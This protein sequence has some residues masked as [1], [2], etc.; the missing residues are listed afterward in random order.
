MEITPQFAPHGE[1]VCFQS[2]G[3][4]PGSWTPQICRL[5]YTWPWDQTLLS[6][7]WGHY[8]VITWSLTL[9]IAHNHLLLSHYRPLSFPSTTKVR[10]LHQSV[11]QSSLHVKCFRNKLKLHPKLWII[12][13]FIFLVTSI[14]FHTQ[15][16]STSQIR[17]ELLSWLPAKCT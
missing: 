13:G 12:T 4:H 9:Q 16:Y 8:E 14:K 15:K 17:R 7:L 3:K 1:Y 11:C 6:C 5:L 2:T 10:C